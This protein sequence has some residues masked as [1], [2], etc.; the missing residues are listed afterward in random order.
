M[1]IALNLA[2]A[3]LALTMAVSG[4]APAAP[5]SSAVQQRTWVLQSLA[6]ASVPEP[7]EGAATAELTLENGK[8]NGNGGVNILTGIYVLDG[9]A[10]SFGSLA[11]TKMA[12]P[13]EAMDQETQFL[14]A[15][16]AAAKVEVD[17]DTLRILQEDGTELMVMVAR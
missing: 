8:V 9:D 11:S 10:L 13:P 6:G 1:K 7:A 3:L 14:S 2:I 4:C 5:D 15:L 16:A 12:G 17:G